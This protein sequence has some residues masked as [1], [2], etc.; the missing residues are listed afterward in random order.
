MLLKPRDW[1]PDSRP[2]PLRASRSATALM[3]SLF[4]H[5]P[6]QPLPQPHWIARNASLARELGLADLL[7]HDPAGLTRFAGNLPLAHPP[8]LA[9]VYSG[10]QFGVWAGQLGDGRALLLGETLGGLELQ[11]K[12]SG[13]TPYSR[14]GDGRAVLRSSLREYLGSEAMHALGVPSTRALC[15]VGSPQPVMRE[16]IETAAVVTRVA[17]SFLRFGHFEHLSHSGQHDALRNLADHVIAR[18]YPE[19]KQALQPYVALLEAIA[20]RTA[21]LVAQWQAVGFCHGVLNTD[22]MSV[23]GLTLD[24]GPFQFLDAYD[25]T[26]ICNHSDTGGRYAFNQQPGVVLWNLHALG[27]AML[28]LLDADWAKVQHTLQCYEP[29]LAS[30]W[31]RIMQAKMGLADALDPVAN[32]DTA[33]DTVDRKLINSL[34]E[35]LARQRVDYCAF[36]A[37]LTD[38]SLQG[39]PSALHALFEDPAALQPWLLQFQERR[40]QI[41]PALAAQFMSASNPRL[42]L[43]THLAELAIQAAEAGDFS[44]AE[45]LLTA[46]QQPFHAPANPTWT[47]P[48]PSWAR[49]LVLSCSS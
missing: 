20:L 31:L 46:L 24:Y 21:D 26:H 11:L 13:L 10:H 12:G 37:S 18:F 45:Q 3:E 47:Q 29:R 27:H 43:R 30:R 16:R 5:V 6:P 34:L 38:W 40:S 44:I 48:A 14:M 36:W 19:L 9:S 4:T 49:T 35:L 32:A 41:A 28:P 1:I 15:L 7:W 17:P 42:I 8:T 33:R 39:D 25:P 22:N 2:A 23:L